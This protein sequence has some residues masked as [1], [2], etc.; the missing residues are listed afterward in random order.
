MCSI[1]ISCRQNNPRRPK[2]AAN[3][4]TAVLKWK[5]TCVGF[6]SFGMALSALIAYIGRCRLLR[7]TH[8]KKSLLQHCGLRLP[9]CVHQ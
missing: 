7:R 6:H 9:L 4:E 3:T 5:I 8:V 1:R 2:S